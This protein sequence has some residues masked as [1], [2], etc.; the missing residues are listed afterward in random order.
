ML[1]IIYMCISAATQL[2]FRVAFLRFG[3]VRLLYTAACLYSVYGCLCGRLLVVLGRNLQFRT[4]ALLQ[5][6][7]SV[8]SCR[9]QPADLSLSS[10][11]V[12]TSDAWLACLS[13]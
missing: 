4:G 2:N 3:G 1:G 13:G 11:V 10:S 12:V 5:R 9:G 7:W 8:G 6:R